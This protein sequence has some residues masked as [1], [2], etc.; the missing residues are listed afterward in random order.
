MTAVFIVYCVCTIT[1]RHMHI[2]QTLQQSYEAGT[3]ILILP[4]GT[5]LRH[6]AAE[7]PAQDT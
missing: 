6:M 1:V 3:S 4:W 7:Y 2:T 5:Y